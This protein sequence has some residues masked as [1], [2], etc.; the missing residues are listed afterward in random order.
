MESAQAKNE[1]E[2]LNMTDILSKTED[3]DFT[4]KT[5]EYSIMQTVYM[6]SLQTGAK[7]LPKTILD[8]L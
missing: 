6:A 4:E 3:I 1:D 2:N 7:V 5:M 8:Y